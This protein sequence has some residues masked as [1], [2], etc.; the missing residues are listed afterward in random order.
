M[1][2]EYLIHD[3]LPYLAE[4]LW[5]SILL[6]IPSMLIGFGGGVLLGT[7]RVFGWSVFRWLGDVY[8]SFVRGVPLVIQLFLL[9]YGLPKLGL[10]LDGFGAA[11]LGFVLCSAAYHSEYIRGALLS[12]RQGQ[13]KGAQAL[14]FSKLAMLTSI[15]VPQALRRAL[16]GCG[17][18][19]IYLIKYSS[20]AYVC[21]CMDLSNCAVDLASREF[22]YFEV[23]LVAGLFYLLLTSLA[24]I[25]LRW[26]ER[27]LYIPG[28]GPAK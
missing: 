17:N 13:L 20:L 10:M 14:G 1:D 16:P 4:G 25:F 27:K 9:Y 24:T 21:T 3:A 15:V 6:I 18:E 7:V 26:L 28:F 5:E 12:I 23:F 11:V 19:V 22:K 8:T 2:F